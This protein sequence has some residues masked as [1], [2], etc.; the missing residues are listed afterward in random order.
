MKSTEYIKKIFLFLIR[1]YQRT[2]SPDHGLLAHRHPYGYCRY[3]PTCSDY[4]HNAIEQHG[5][6]K[7][8]LLTIKRIGR[9]HPWSQGGY[10]P[11]PKK[12]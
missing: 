4:G 1:L 5:L 10:D 7:G 11:V 9:C 6:I 8:G 3:Y 2:L 12:I